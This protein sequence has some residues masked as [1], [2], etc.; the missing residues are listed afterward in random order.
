MSL[1]EDRLAFH[2]R[3]VDRARTVAPW[4]VPALEREHARM[5]RSVHSL[6]PK[7][8]GRPKETRKE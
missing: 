4:N 1:K 6:P 5:A 8:E 7:P 2:A 3:Y